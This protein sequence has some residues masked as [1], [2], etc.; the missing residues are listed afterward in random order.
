[1]WLTVDVASLVQIAL[2]ASVGAVLTAYFLRGP[3]TRF[4]LLALT[5]A[6]C[7]GL[8]VVAFIGMRFPDFPLPILIGALSAAAPITLALAPVPVIKT[9]ADALDVL[10]RT[11][12]SLT[13]H[14]IYG[15]AFAALGFA[16]AL[17]AALALGIP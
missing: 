2:A 11:A 9:A 17:G 4:A 5:G 12:A 15:I 8:G 14:V 1:M 13:L 16:C 10:R 6:V 3:R 7:A